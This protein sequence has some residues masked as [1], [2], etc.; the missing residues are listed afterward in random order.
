M[1][2]ILS[3]REASGVLKGLMRPGA[4]AVSRLKLVEKR[5][6]SQAKGGVVQAKEDLA[7]VQALRRRLALGGYG[8]A[9]GK[10]KVI[11][12]IA[13][14]KIADKILR[15]EVGAG[16]IDAERAKYS[17]K[18]ILK[19]EMRELAKAAQT[20]APAKIDER[21][22]TA[23]AEELKKQ[24]QES[25]A[26]VYTAQRRVEALK[27]QAKLESEALKRVRDAKVSISRVGSAETPPA[28]P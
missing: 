19:Q 1:E 24:R 3:R 11:Q 2:D 4:P 28:A 21:R 13:A 16:I 6:A 18:T 20:E 7:K 15:Q 12:D 8:A 17:P 26:K 25:T 23:L 27:E 22:T 9:A 14:A 5:L 10:S